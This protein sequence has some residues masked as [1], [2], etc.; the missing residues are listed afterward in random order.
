M[1]TLERIAETKKLPLSYWQAEVKKRRESNLARWPHARGLEVTNEAKAT[2]AVYMSAQGVKQ[3]DIC[4]KLGITRC[5]FWRLNR[6]FYPL[7]RKRN[8]KKF[9]HLLVM[10]EMESRRNADPRVL[11]ARIRKLGAMIPHTKGGSFEGFPPEVI[12]DVA[13]RLGRRLMQHFG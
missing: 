1:T 12:L 10:A 13:I 6:Q 8:P 7:L 2:Q 5:E 9:G 11:A 4:A 3:D